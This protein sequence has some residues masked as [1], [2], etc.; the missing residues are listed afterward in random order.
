M[1]IFWKN[2]TLSQ[3]KQALEA[4]KR[5]LSDG[6]SSARKAEARR[7]IKYLEKEIQGRRRKAV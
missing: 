1:S 4:R 2:L 6:T 3:L 5:E 7:A